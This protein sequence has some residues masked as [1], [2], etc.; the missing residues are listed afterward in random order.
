MKNV[1]ALF[2]LLP[3][4]CLSQNP[5]VISYSRFF[6]KNDKQAELRKSLINHS[7]KFHTG[8]WKWR[9]Y[10]LDSGPDA[11]GY[12]AIEGPTT[13]DQI[14]NRK[15]ISAD[16]VGDLAKNV[17]P[18]TIDKNEQGYMVFREDLSS[19]KITDYSDKVSIMHV[20]PKPGKMP[21]VEEQLKLLKKVWEDGNESVAVY[22]A[23]SSGPNQFIIVTR[24]KQG[25]KE[26]ELGFRKPMKERYNTSN[27]EGS[28][29]K[30]VAATSDLLDHQWAEM[31]SFESDMS[32][33]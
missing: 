11:G 7:T 10:S 16:H 9:I 27:G 26:K 14:D 18:L 8:T 25:L 5:S 32:S 17:L 3:L 24:Y 30:Y 28:F 33:K 20:F 31:A 12:L 1:F 13:W 6:A 19:V 2:F 29:D 4:Y 21:G 22:Q 15:D 23:S